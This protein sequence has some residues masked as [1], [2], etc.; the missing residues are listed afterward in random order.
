[1]AAPRTMLPSLPPTQAET[2]AVSTSCKTIKPGDLVIVYENPKCM[3]AV[4]V[5]ENGRFES[6]FGSF[7]HKVRSDDAGRSRER[8]RGSMPGARGWPGW[9]CM[10]TETASSSVL[11]L[12]AS[13]AAFL[14]P[15]HKQNTCAG[16]CAAYCW[17]H[18]TG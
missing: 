6:R 11:L 9:G 2:D 13:H 1:M 18:R 17:P 3:K 4:Y 14:P 10:H 5:S 7:P 15:K 8:E 16:A 12:V